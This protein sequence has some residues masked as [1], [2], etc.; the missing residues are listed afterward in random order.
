MR[1]LI[2]LINISVSEH[3]VCIATDN[4]GVEMKIN[5]N[6]WLEFS[7]AKKTNEVLVLKVTR[8]L[9]KITQKTENAGGD[10][11]DGLDLFL[12]RISHKMKCY[13]NMI[14]PPM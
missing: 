10:Y 14:E 2:W 8:R 1:S 12:E 13:A 5:C 7:G 9:H 3:F 6:K 4:F 11:T